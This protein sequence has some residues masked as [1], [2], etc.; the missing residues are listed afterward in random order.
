LK[1]LLYIFFNVYT[2]FALEEDD[3][4]VGEYECPET[5]ELYQVSVFTGYS[6]CGGALLSDGWVLSAALN[7]IL[8]QPSLSTTDQPE[9]TWCSEQL[10]VSWDNVPDFW[11]G[12]FRPSDE[13]CEL[14]ATYWFIKALFHAV[15]SQT[16]ADVYSLSGVSSKVPT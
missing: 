1:V 11:L 3:K 7:S 4:H 2:V 14:R 8:I 15:I 16:L 13:G 12:S 10:C 5:S 9:S 6:N